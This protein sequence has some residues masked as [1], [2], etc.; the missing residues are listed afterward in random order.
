M[1]RRLRREHNDRAWLAWHTAYLT[2]YP[3]RKPRE[4]T[5]LDKLLWKEQP[6][7]QS[8]AEMRDVARRWIESVNR[9][10]KR[11]KSS[12]KPPDKED[13]KG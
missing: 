1:K 12:N 6:K 7:S 5:K 13:G 11:K 4:F 2:A 10:N 8:I 9:Q 3:P